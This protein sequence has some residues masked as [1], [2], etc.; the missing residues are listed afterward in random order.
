LTDS[1]DYTILG[2]G[3]VGLSTA[4]ELLEIDPSLKLRIID[5]KV[6]PIGASTKNAGFACFGSVSEIADDVSQYGFEVASQ[7]IAMRWQGL[8]RLRSRV[9]ADLMQYREQP[10][11]E[12]FESEEQAEEYQ[13]L[14]PQYN[15][16]VRS[17]NGKSNCF[18]YQ[19]E[20]HLGPEISNR[21]EG[22]LHPQMMMDRLELI[23]RNLGV[24]IL[25]GIE[26]EEIDQ[27][28]KQL[29]TPQGL[30]DYQH[31]IVCTNGFTKQLM[32]AIDLQP[33]RNQV[34][35]TDPI[36]GFELS[37]CYHMDKGYVYFREIG[38]RL[39][40]GGG[41]HLDTSGEMTTKLGSTPLI[42]DFLHKTIRERIL[43]H[44]HYTVSQS[45]SGILGVGSSKMPIVKAVDPNLTVAVR[46]GGM[47]VAVGSYIGQLTA[48]ILTD[49]D[50]S[51]RRL[52]VIE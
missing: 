40:I 22:S 4:L 45:W 27:T 20:G 37:G 15:N 43:G 34:L 19:R 44:D 14:V 42:Q 5:Q 31:L 51:A 16:L 35:I 12:V 46:M 7:L 24:V 11:V 41:R 17:I 21:L 13:K 52:F 48:A 36:D 47:G 29:V 50:N 3:I 32:P 38:S 26:V 10:G 1:F 23:A 2:M 25:Q 9:S 18:S 8:K 6:L 28:N 39:L 49:T 30:V 33:A